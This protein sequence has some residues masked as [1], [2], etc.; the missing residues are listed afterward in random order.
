M[1]LI[2]YGRDGRTAEV[3]KLFLGMDTV[4]DMI[5]ENGVEMVKVPGATVNFFKGDFSGGTN[6][7]NGKYHEKELATPDEVRRYTADRKKERDLR[8]ELLLDRHI[9]EH[10]QKFDL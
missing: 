7:G 9:G 6:H 10:L 2:L 3:E 8:S 5:I 4:P 1:P